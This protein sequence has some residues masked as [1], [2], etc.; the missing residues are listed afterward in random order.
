MCFPVAAFQQASCTP[1]ASF[2]VSM[3]NWQCVLVLHA[4]DWGCMNGVCVCMGGC[5]QVCSCGCVWVLRGTEKVSIC[6]VLFLSFSWYI[7][8]CQQSV[9]AYAHKQ[10]MSMFVPY[11]LCVSICC[12]TGKMGCVWCEGGMRRGGAIL[13]HL[14]KLG[15]ISELEEQLIRLVPFM[16]PF[17]II[18]LPNTHTCLLNLAYT[19]NGR[20]QFNIRLYPLSPGCGHL[21]LLNFYSSCKCERQTLPGKQGN[22]YLLDRRFLFTPP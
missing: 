17:K 8:R 15:T 20:Q 5:W 13:C 10:H 14:L 19:L 7:Q 16:F 9:Y 2:C 1:L 3:A 18:L 22:P 12:S 6:C 11:I 21:C 4:S